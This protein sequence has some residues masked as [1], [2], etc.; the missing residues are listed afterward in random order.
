MNENIYNSEFIREIQN[1]LRIIGI[2]TGKSEL[3]IPETGIF[4][5]T[6][7][8]AII[9]FKSLYGLPLTADIDSDS[10]DKL[11]EIFKSETS[12]RGPTAPIRPYP[13]SES[14]EL[15]FGE[16]SELVYILQLM[17]NALSIYY[18]DIPRIPVN[19]TFGSET[20][21]AVRLFQKINTLPITGIVDRLTWEH[22]AEEYN[23]S[24]NDS[25]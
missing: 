8:N 13:R 9:T 19:G 2:S 21:N 14:Y 20:E 24:V 10:Y 17:L 1:I 18:Y 7:Q 11:T 22:L 23:E 6:T 16:V 15:A 25:Q 12:L 4:D 5:N 3:V